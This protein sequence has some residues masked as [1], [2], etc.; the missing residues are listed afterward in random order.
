MSDPVQPLPNRLVVRIA[1]DAP[2]CVASV[3]KVW[4]GGPVNPGV[5]LRVA[6]AM[7]AQGL[8]PPP[9]PA[10]A[11]P[12]LVARQAGADIRT[13]RRVLAGERVGDAAHAR[14]IAALR[15][16]GVEVPAEGGGDDAA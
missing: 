14:I 2:A 6:A 13:V 3:R 15:E 10:S 12:S 11:A 5:Y 1:A 16:L 8:R 9:P 7:R 4:G